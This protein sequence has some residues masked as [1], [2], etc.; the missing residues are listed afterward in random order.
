V[1]A[2][3]LHDAEAF[4][5]ADVA[6]RL[7]K[8]SRE[9]DVPRV[10]RWLQAAASKEGWRLLSPAQE[11]FLDLALREPISVLTGGPGTGK[12]FA[13]HIAVRLWRAMGR[14][15]LMCAPTG[16]AAQ[17]LAEIATAGR[18]MSAARAELDHPPAFGDAA[19]GRKGGA[20][21]TA[22]TTTSTR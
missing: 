5:A 2:S 20:R 22:T 14:K 6:A 7:R 1:F 17:R 13:T 12:T 18:R 21:D 4:V 9:P 19:K 16:R 3:V 10:R 11:A 15:V 8:P